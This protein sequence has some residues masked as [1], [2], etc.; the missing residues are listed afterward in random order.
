MLRAAGRRCQSSVLTIVELP[1]PKTL[2]P[3]V[4]IVKVYKELVKLH[5][6]AQEAVL[7]TIRMDRN[8]LKDYLDSRRKE[9]VDIMM[10]LF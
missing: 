4:A 10:T 3:L 9:V 5:G 8:V 6:R 1:M 2:L 7:E